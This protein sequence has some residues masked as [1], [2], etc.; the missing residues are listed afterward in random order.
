MR[1]TCP[2]GVAN[3]LED[4]GPDTEIAL[5]AVPSERIGVEDDTSRAL[6]VPEGDEGRATFRVRAGAT[7]G[8]A[9]LTLTARLGETVV[10]RNA[11]LS[12][13]PA[14]AF[15][16]TLISGF[17]AGGSTQ[18]ALPRRL[19]E[20]F[21]SQRVAASASPLVLADGML[22]YLDT[23]PHAC[24]EQIVS[25]VFPQLGLMQLSS[26]PLDRSTFGALFERTLTLLRSRQDASRRNPLLGHLC[27]GRAVPI[28]VH[29]ALYDRCAGAGPWR[30]PVICWVPHYATYG[31]SPVRRT[32][33]NPA[34]T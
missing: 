22:E 8:A 12:V 31:G 9:E 10:R 18:L 3:N 7:P 26:F 24:A 5:T 4:S 27:R 30:C 16:T 33:D 32:T 15:E 2:V 6:V 1:S 21:A 34:Q 28:G 29:N 23:F 14:V 19:H 25:K 20:A 13:R 11:G 17:D